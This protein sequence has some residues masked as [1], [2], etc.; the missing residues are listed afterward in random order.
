MV[1]VNADGEVIFAEEVSL[2]IGARVI[3]LAVETEPSFE[4]LG[5]IFRVPE[6]SDRRRQFDG[7]VCHLIRN[8]IILQTTS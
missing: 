6:K 1:P 4:Y 5:D 7:T 8:G 2:N 3:M